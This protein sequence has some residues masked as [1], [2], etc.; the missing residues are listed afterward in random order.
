V[1]GGD[2]SNELV[3]RLVLVFEH[4][5]GVV[6][7]SLEQVKFSTFVRTRRW[8]RA[9]NVLVV[10]DLL[11][12]QMWHVTWHLH[13]QLEVVTFLHPDAVEPIADWIDREDLPVHRV[14]NT[15]PNKLARKVAT[16]PDLAAIFDPDPAHVLTFGR[17]GRIIN[18]AQPDIL[19]AW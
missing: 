11:A 6:P 14:W 3:P 5:V 18:P 8:R 17:T 7:N 4:L 10:N 16:M 19:R 2:L 13:H 1:Q 9:V 12:K 15:E